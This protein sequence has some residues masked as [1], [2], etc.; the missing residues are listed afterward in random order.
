MY[1]GKCGKQSTDGIRYCIHCGADMAQQTPLPPASAGTGDDV[2]IEDTAALRQEM[3]DASKP[4]TDPG[5]TPGGT[6]RS[7]RMVPID[8]VGVG[9]MLAE[10]YKIV[11]RLGVGGMGEVFKALDGELNDLT[12]AIKVLPPMLAANTRSVNRLRT[13][14]AISLK[15]THPCICRLHTFR[16]DGNVK[17]LVME[18]IPGQTLEEMLDAT[19]TR[20]LALAKLLPIARNVA[21]ALDF[22][23]S[24]NPPILHRDIKPSNVMV[25]PEGLGKVLDFGIARELKDSMTR[26]TGKDTSGTLLYMSP[27]QFTGSTPSAASDIYSFAAMLYEC[28]CGHAPF[29][30]GS[31][32]HQLLNQVPVRLPGMPDHVNDALQAGLA[33]NSA[34]RPATAREMVHA[35]AGRG[36]NKATIADKRAP[37]KPAAPIE[38]R[39]PRQRA[40]KDEPK[41][42]PKATRPAKRRHPFRKLFLLLVLLAGVAATGYLQGWWPQEVLEWSQDAL[43]GIGVNIPPGKKSDGVVTTTPAKPVTPV[44]V[45]DAVAARKQAESSWAEVKNFAPENGFDLK[46]SAVEALVATGADQITKKHYAE[47]MATFTDVVARCKVIEQLNVSR[48]HAQAARIEVAKAR[49]AAQAV[50]AAMLA[51]ALWQ[52]AQA[53]D[54]TAQTRFDAGDFANA[55]SGWQEAKRDYDKAVALATLAARV[56]EA[57]TEWDDALAAADED[58]LGKYGG[59]MWTQAQNEMTLARAAGTT[60]EAPAQWRTATTSLGQAWV[61]ASKGYALEQKIAAHLAN[62]EKLIDEDK[63]A[64]SRAEA[65]KA[66]ALAPKHKSA[67]FI[68]AKATAGAI[69]ALARGGAQTSYDEAMAKVREVTPDLKRLAEEQPL[70]AKVRAWLAEAENLAAQLANMYRFSKQITGHDK[71]VTSLDVSADG[72]EFI[73]TSDDGTVKIWGAVTGPLLKT[74]DVGGQVV[75]AVYSPDGKRLAWGTG[76]KLTIAP[77]MGADKPVIREDH[78]LSILAVRFAPSGKTMITCGGDKKLFARDA[79]S[80]EVTARM[81]N[82]EDDVTCVAF[83]SDSKRAVSGSGKLTAVQKDEV[84]KVWDL[85]GAEPKCVLSLGGHT[86]MIRAVAFSADDKFIASADNDGLIVLRHG[87]TGKVVHTLKGHRAGVTDLCFRKDG[88]RLASASM[89]KTIVIWDLVSGKSVQTLEAH[90]APVRAVRFTRDERRVLS[91]GDDKTIII[92]SLPTA[93]AERSEQR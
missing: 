2:T 47:A 44:G 28:L 64:E 69:L 85:T 5:K 70:D 17:F 12:V 55:A 76:T 46:L 56:K 1:C 62:A 15:L 26:M 71:A 6:P 25:T 75:S 68:A 21:G 53:G 90:T 73:T 74:I 8:A 79:A 23:H 52:G 39:E 88:L 27:E 61:T 60:E 58:A 11:D 63:F 18:H 77:R 9:R 33:K 45:D 93:G 83:S 81:D 13:E 19:D 40:P 92:W 29:W 24:Q 43:A 78:L 66:L 31:I 30:Q 86:R 48:Q 72:T 7:P 37:K 16:V 87:D 65:D 3:L 14:A 57:R 50:G 67:T 54:T 51:D 42:E 22:A 89:D 49:E 36:S 20:R 91:A 32:A 34:D 35:L 41:A 10:R 59:E 82:D 4:P 80:G 38:P 84:V